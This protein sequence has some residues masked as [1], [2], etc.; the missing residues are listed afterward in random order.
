[1]MSFTNRN[2]RWKPDI[3]AIGCPTFGMVSE[4]R[5]R[6][7]K[8]GW[9]HLEISR[10]QEHKHHQLPTLYKQN[11]NRNGSIHQRSAGGAAA[12]ELALKKG[13]LVT[14]TEDDISVN[15]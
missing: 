5:D 8:A 6:C 10:N 14:V 13:D 3:S 12:V 2:L 1:M 9:D 15:C 11:A 4:N 7:Q